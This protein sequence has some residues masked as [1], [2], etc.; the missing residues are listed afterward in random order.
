MPSTWRKFPVELLGDLM[1][2]FGWEPDKVQAGPATK[3][4]LGA[5]STDPEIRRAA[6]RRELDEVEP[7]LHLLLK[8]VEALTT[9]PL[10]RP[11]EYEREWRDIIATWNQKIRDRSWLEITPLCEVCG[12]P[13]QRRGTW[14]S[15]EKPNLPQITFV[16]SDRCG[17]TQRQRGY[18]LGAKLKEPAG[19]TRHPTKRKP[20]KIISSA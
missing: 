2:A 16:C 6:Y 19:T 11:N 7:V 17:A 13:V 14:R 4:M 10:L 9:F 5:V 8:R 3:R 12:K 15:E 18:R 1:R 20:R